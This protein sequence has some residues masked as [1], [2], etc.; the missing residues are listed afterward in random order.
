MVDETRQQEPVRADVTPARARAQAQAAATPS[1]RTPMVEI[2]GREPSDTSRTSPRMRFDVLQ[3]GAW[4]SGLYLV[5]AGLVAVARAG[6][7]DLELFAPV[8]TVGNQQ[9]TPLYAGLFLVLGIAVLKAGTGSV[10]ERGLRVGGVLFAIAGAVLLIEPEAFSEYLGVTDESGV[11][12]LAIGALLA[13]ASFVPPLSIARP[14]V[15]DG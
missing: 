4:A 13:A 6:L 3:I 1:G 10:N 12:L 11:L 8:V 2:A 15:R 14:G 9:L 5:V 7:E